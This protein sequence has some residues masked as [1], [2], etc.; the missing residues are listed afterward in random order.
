MAHASPG[1]APRHP[2]PLRHLGDEFAGLRTL[3]FLRDSEVFRDPFCV[4]PAEEAYRWRVCPT[5]E[6]RRVAPIVEAY[7]LHRL[8]GS[9]GTNP[10]AALVEAVAILAEAD[11]EMDLA[12]LEEVRLHG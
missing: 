10:S 8:T 2:L 1:A 6:I 12:F 5:S 11:L 4:S 7:R 9:L 3:P